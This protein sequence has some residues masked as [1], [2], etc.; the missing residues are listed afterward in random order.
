MIKLIME[1]Q[2]E[3]HEYVLYEGNDI[4]AAM[5]LIRHIIIIHYRREDENNHSVYFEIQDKYGFSILDLKY[6]K[7][8]FIN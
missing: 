5:D 8:G 1:E 6:N 3:E 7:S 4:A 2:G